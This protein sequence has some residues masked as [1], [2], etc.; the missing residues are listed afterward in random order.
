MAQL[1]LNTLAKYSWFILGYNLLVIAF[2]AYV[3]ASGS[4]AGC[5]SHWP[6]CNGEVIPNFQRFET[7]IEFSHRLTSGLVLPLLLVLVYGVFKKFSKGHLARKSVIL[8]LIFTVIEALIGAGLVKWGLVEKNDS[9]ARAVVM[10]AHLANT[11]FLLA[12]LAVV[13]WITSGN[14]PFQIRKQGALGWGLLL[15]LIGSLILGVSGAVTALGDTLFPAANF[16]EGLKQDF[17][18][19]AHFLIRLRLFHPLIATSV[20][21]LLVFIFGLAMHKRPSEKVR[22][23]GKFCIAVYCS[24]LLLG[25]I[26]VG[27]SAPIEIQLIHLLLA[28][29]LWIGMILLTIEVLSQKGFAKEAIVEKMVTKEKLTPKQLISQYVALTKPRVISLLLFTTLAG[30]FIAQGGWPGGF[31]LFALALGG[32]MMAGGANA[33]NMVIERDLDERMERTAGRPIVAEYISTKNALIFATILAI[34]SFVLLTYAANLLSALLALAGL[35][36][37]VIVYTLVLKRRTWHNIVIGGAA[38]AFP[39]L[40]GY[41]AVSQELTPLAWYLFAIIFLWTP[42]HFWALALILKDD[43]K[44]AGV[45]M[46]PVVHGEKTTVVQIG[47]YALLTALVSILPFF[48][49]DLGFIYLVPA[50]IL[51]G[52]L[53]LMSLKLYIQPSYGRAFSLFK[54]SMV[55]LALLFLL[56]A[57]DRAQGI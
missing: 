50:V 55:Y 16:I 49:R 6:A 9:I 29:I 40:V 3:R 27:L 24:Q 18:P 13:A 12:S 31:L 15:T 54:Y 14:K 45:P 36:F 56:I 28:D 8:V 25:L 20:G 51:N 34:G 39:P 44:K 33:I 42:V 37:Y 5:G 21:L 1:K 2:G 7:I 57:I 22:R 46:L 32:Y 52:I 10:S 47:L 17:S 23:L 41:A 26:N 38:G 4:G 53:L 11:F 30:A 19:T 43:Y 35:A 48:Q